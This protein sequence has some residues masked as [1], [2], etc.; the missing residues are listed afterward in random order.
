M[1]K[2]YTPLPG[3]KNESYTRI[4]GKGEAETIKFDL[5]PLEEDIGTVNSV[6]WTVKSGQAAV[7]GES[8][9]S[10]IASALITVSEVGRSRIEVQFTDGTEIAVRTL[11]I[12]AREPQ[13][14]ANDDYGLVI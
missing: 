10:S 7:S 9:S 8:L 1:S 13:T 11:F 4:L 5:K 14:T 3:R 12:R 6:T 2:T